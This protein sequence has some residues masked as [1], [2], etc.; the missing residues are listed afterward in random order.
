MVAS[1]AD[2]SIIAHYIVQLVLD[3]LLNGQKS[4]F[5][6]DLYLIGLK[7][8]WVFDFP[9]QNHAIHVEAQQSPNIMTEGEV[10]SPED[11]TTEWVNFMRDL[12]SG[13]ENAGSDPK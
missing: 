12:L 13:D 2:V 3:S 10:T 5:P 7:K 6:E 1:D 9:F 4:I 11:K 8:G